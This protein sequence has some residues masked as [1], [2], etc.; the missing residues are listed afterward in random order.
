MDQYL[1]KIDPEICCLDN[2]MLWHTLAERVFRDWQ[3]SPNDLNRLLVC[4][5]QLWYMLE[6][7]EYL[8][9]DSNP[10]EEFES[11][12]AE[13]VSHRLQEVVSYGLAHFS[14]N[15]PFNAYFGYLF[16]VK[17]EYFVTKTSGYLYW[18]E[19]GIS[20]IKKAHELD[21]NSPF[22]R[23]LYYQLEAYGINEAC[24][25]IWEQ[26]TPA[27]WGQ[28]NFHC[29]MFSILWGDNFYPDAYST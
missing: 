24:R 11:I 18:Y 15:A 17:P 8:R 13:T 4:G 21:P 1:L 29:Y 23:A 6:L 2:Q 22:T 26:I 27:Q 9:L 5:T 25:E 20:M 3:E 14:D 7:D 16:K 19:K 12:C 28:T 10:P